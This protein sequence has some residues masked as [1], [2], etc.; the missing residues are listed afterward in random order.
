MTG[1]PV[2]VVAVAALAVTC[3]TVA[4]G[5]L[6]ALALSV[7]GGQPPE[8]AAPA[9]G[10][11]RGAWMALYMLIAVAG[12]VLAAA[13]GGIGRSKLG[14]RRT[15]DALMMSSPI[16]AIFDLTADRSHLGRG[17]EVTVGHWW[18]AGAPVIPGIAA[19]IAAARVAGRRDRGESGPRTG[20]GATAVRETGR[21]GP[22]GVGNMAEDG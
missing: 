16:G 4:I 12:P 11:R 20:P 9:R 5:G 15:P 1:W 18:W 7:E 8:S 19:G 21:G 22:A 17:A 14:D 2:P 6:L 10:S 3:W 13:L